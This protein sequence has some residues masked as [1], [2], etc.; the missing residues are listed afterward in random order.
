MA[1]PIIKPVADPFEDIDREA[2]VDNLMAR[3]DRADLPGNRSDAPGNRDP[4]RDADEADTADLQ[5]DGPADPA[6][7]NSVSLDEADPDIDQAIE[8]L[9]GGRPG[10]GPDDDEPVEETER[11]GADSRT[12]TP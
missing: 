10:I 1:T 7:R 5:A 12:G 11:L 2:P 9:A 8:E 6:L 3:Q 4:G